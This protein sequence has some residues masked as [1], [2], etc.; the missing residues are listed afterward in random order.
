MSC[1]K[2]LVRGLSFSTLGVMLSGFVLYQVWTNPAATRA[3]VLDKLAAR[4]QGANVRL[5]SAQM[6]LLG[7]IAINE[8]RMSR[9]DSLDPDFLCVPSAVI[10]HDKEQILNGVL[11]IRKIELYRPTLRLVRER[12]GT[13]NL[14]GL[15]G[16]P[17]SNE[18]M[19]TVVI[20]QG[21][22]L[23]EDRACPSGP[24][25]VEMKDVNVT[26]L[27]DPPSVLV[28]EGTG[29]ADV[30]GPFHFSARV[31][32]PNGEISAT[33]EASAV[34]VGPS[35][36]QRLAVASPELAGHLRQLHGTGN[37]QA[38]LVYHPGMTRPLDYDVTARLTN[39]EF[40]HASLPLPLEQ[41]DASVHCVNGKVPT[42]SLTARSGP[43]KLEVSLKDLDLPTKPLTSPAEFDRLVREIDARVEHLPVSGDLLKP[44]P[45]SVTLYTTA[46]EFQRQYSPSGPL[47]LAYS[48]RREGTDGWRKRW[49]VQ[50]EGMS[51]A[52][53]H[54]AY[55]V[56]RVTGTIESEFTSS[57]AH[58]TKVDLLGSA[59]S[60]PVTLKGT[61]EGDKATGPV[62]LD[63]AADNVPLDNKLLSALSEKYKK[64]AEEF[65]PAGLGDFRVSL[66]REPGHEHMANRFV[67]T[68]HDSSVK[69]NLFPLALEGLRGVLDIQPDHWECRGVRGKHNGGEI[70]VEGR[71]YKRTGPNEPAQFPAVVQAS[72]K[73]VAQDRIRLTIRGKDVA[74][75]KDFVEALTKSELPC[76]PALQKTWEILRPSGQLNFAAEVDDCPS[77][78]QEID[79]AV[80]LRG[81]A[82]RPDFFRYDMDEVSAGVRYV[83]NR[84]YLSD[85]QARHG[86]AALGVKQGLILLQ[87]GNGVYTRLVGV[88]GTGVEADADL[89]RAVPERLRKG[90]E[91]LKIRGPI[92]VETDLIVD[93]TREGEPVPVVW[94]D[95]GARLRDATFQAGVD[96]SGVTGVVSCCGKHNGLQLDKVVGHVH[97]DRATLLDQPVRNVH[98]RLEVLPQTPEALGLR[99]LKAELFGGTVGGEARIEFSPSMRYFVD[100]KAVQVQLQEFGAHN[101]I[102]ELQG[103][104]TA[105]VYLEGEGSQLSGLKGHGQIDVADGKL[106]H[107]HPLLDL[108]KTFGLRQP[109]RTA[110]EQAHMVFA[111]E[112]P[113]LKVRQMELLGNAIS[114]HGQGELNLDGS[115]LGLDFAAT[116]GRLTQV[117]PPL[118]DGIPLAISDQ[119]LKVKVRGNLTKPR[120]EPDIVPGVTGPL[121]KVLR[122]SPADK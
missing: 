76:R 38:S 114:L 80:N 54:F 105:A 103:P 104:A 26:L 113:R 29:R 52:F 6:R 122:A 66:R 77:Q 50:P 99:D 35:L 34:P 21:T 7:G 64:L 17:D 57:R 93:A 61:V 40:T 69:Y 49:V 91:N 109:D 37:V 71:S 115:D 15:T 121:K 9:R 22:V 118:L 33:V 120:Y 96:V 95:G 5:D 108:M 98:A 47:T 25:T 28:A 16:K 116:P 36:I 24:A 59:S 45:D 102:G 10:Y 82:I 106:Y 110:F 12:D 65:H 1:R 74:L 42:A 2:W 44:I 78:P 70:S 3:L 63:L 97:F 73:A 23:L 41:L 56:E 72:A 119:L 4:F 62:V 13:C 39:G 60:Q 8:L 67:V 86:T 107:L 84:V 81:C 92:D 11:A 87:P 117:L 30:A 111:F 48:F 94:W 19:P 20:H 32:R 27:N 53:I 58:R 85:F 90:V 79:V 101:H 31:Q 89:L 100:L 68:F 88:K 46:R 83:Q 51:G 112:G 75:D 43:A 55:P 14:D 18:R